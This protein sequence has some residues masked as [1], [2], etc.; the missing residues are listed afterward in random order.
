M[1][2]KFLALVLLV[3]PA[4]AQVGQSPGGGIGFPRRG[5]QNKVSPKEKTA[6]EN[7]T[8]IRGMLRAINDEAILVEAAD[9]RILSFKR[10]EKTRFIKNGEDIKPAAFS[11]GDH[12]EVES[13]QDEKGYL[14]AVSLALEKTG[15]AS[16][17]ASASRP[18]EVEMRA[19][20]S[21]EDER[22]VLRRAGELEK[23]PPAPA[24]AATVTPAPAAVP[25]PE[26]AADDE[27]DDS[28]PPRLRRGKP[29]ARAPRQTASARIPEKFPPP[30]PQA[31][32]PAPAAAAVPAPA[33]ANPII[34]KARETALN[35]TETLPN[36]ICQQVTARFI[37]TSH[38]PNWRPQD[39]VTAEVV[40]ENGKE[41]YRN[42]KINNKPVKDKAPEASGAWSTG[43]FATV[44]V[45]VFSPST[46]ADF[47]F[48]KD[49]VIA[50]Q[51][52]KVFDFT[53]D[54]ENSHW[55]I[56]APSQSVRPA[57]KGSIWIDTRTHR[58]LRI[59]M[60]A[61]YMPAEFPFDKVE[62]ATDYEY[63]RLGE[64][65]FLLPVHA[66][67]LM[68]ERGTNVCS[69]NKIDFR[70]YHKYAGEATITFEPKPK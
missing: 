50:G 53:V 35:F 12:V 69:S 47:R 70:N 54:R 26:P 10:S 61:M 32:P 15:S 22:P 8:S 52:A 28:G 65:Q 44:L 39:V 29:T 24:A 43:E 11:P 67:S 17:K 60:Q 31:A 55:S 30:V 57:Y 59:E 66:E 33:A 62:S 13:L 40:Y 5:K 7:T 3:L 34:E 19:P 37:T 18:L 23:L 56:Q 25:P 68:C 9:T 45:D 27:D 1:S 63:V 46:A 51:N 49:A 4:A 42:L 14:Y 36:Y 20:P 64:S 21:D 58:A 48:R 6:P 41:S 38:T 16:E 2:R